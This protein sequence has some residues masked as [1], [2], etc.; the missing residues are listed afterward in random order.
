MIYQLVT[1]ETDYD[2]DPNHLVNSEE[3]IRKTYA[4]YAVRNNPRIRIGATF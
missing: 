4:S 2:V 3:T 1:I